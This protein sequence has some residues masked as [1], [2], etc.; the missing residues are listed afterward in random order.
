MLASGIF[1]ILSTR[2]H[3]YA[4]LRSLSC[5]S[6]SVSGWGWIIPLTGEPV[7]VSKLFLSSKGD[8]VFCSF[9]KCHPFP[10]LRGEVCE[11]F[12]AQGDPEWDHELSAAESGFVA[13][14]VQL[15]LNHNTVSH[16]SAF[17]IRHHG[18]MFAC[19]WNTERQQNS[20]Q[21][22]FWEARKK[23][24]Q[25]KKRRQCS[26]LSL[27][28]KKFFLNL[29]IFHLLTWSVLCMS[30]SV[31]VAITTLSESEAHLIPSVSG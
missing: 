4:E 22:F 15:A 19:C 8:S 14:P 26:K 5:R 11:D 9:W 12:S 6:L 31:L 3:D 24:E 2:Y 21:E 13:A 10:W 7:S 1:S 25:N 16:D 18:V 17:E 28:S 23:Q 27:C 30:E 29:F 20:W